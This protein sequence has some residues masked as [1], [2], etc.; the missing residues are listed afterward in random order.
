MTH[1]P[2]VLASASPRRV[3]LLAQVGVAPDLVDPADMDET[4]GRDET[5]PRLAERLSRGKAEIVAD[6]HPGAFVL[7][8]DTVVAVGRRLLPKTET[9]AEAR[10]CLDLMSGRA[11]QVFSGVCLRGPDGRT[12]AR[13]SRTRVRMK[14]LT[15]QEIDGYLATGEWRGKAGGY[16]VQGR[17]GGFVLDLAGSYSGVVGLPLY[18]T[19]CLLEGLGWRRPDGSAP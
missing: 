6:R 11:H 17:A 18:E 19:L 5:P 1:V 7:A 4:P 3:D 13:V 16:A 10:A 9:E 15:A 12:A 8:A 2:L 14:R